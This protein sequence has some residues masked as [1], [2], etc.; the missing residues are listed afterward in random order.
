MFEN[1]PIDL[2]NLLI[3]IMPGFFFL[4]FFSNKKRSGFEY[5]I[6]S[7]FWGIILVV[8]YYYILP[9]DKFMALIENPYA[10]GIAFSLFSVILALSIKIFI[11]FIR[12]ISNGT[13]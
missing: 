4:K 5:M 7:L 6:L 10:A 11:E 9:T 12:K 1:I 8:L 2:F 3:F 13:W